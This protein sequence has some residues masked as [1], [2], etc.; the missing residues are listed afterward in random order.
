GEAPRGIV[1][2]IGAVKPQRESGEQQQ[3]QD[4]EEDWAHCALPAPRSVRMADVATRPN[5]CKTYADQ[6]FRATCVTRRSLA[7]CCSGVRGLPASPEAN[8][9]CE[10]R[11]R[12][13]S[14]TWRAASRMRASTWAASSRSPCFVVSRPST[15]SAVGRTWRSGL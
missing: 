8:P 15:T 10:L 4:Y 11:A 14:A 12:R 13:G 5:N 7:S 9:H 1:T 3:E 6:T 2:P